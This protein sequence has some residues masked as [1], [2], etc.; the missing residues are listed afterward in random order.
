MTG[1]VPVGLVPLRVS[2]SEQSEMCSQLLFGERVE[3]LEVREKWLYLRNL[4]DDYR[5]WADRKMIYILSEEEERNLGNLVFK[6]IQVP[7]SNYRDN[8]LSTNVLLPGGS[9]IPHDGDKQYQ[10]ANKNITVRTA[11]LVEEAATGQRIVDLAR[12]YQGAPYLWGGK[13]VLGIDCSGLV[14]VVY[15]M[16]DILLPRDASQQVLCGEK[17]ESLAEIKAGDLAF[18]K[19]AKDR[20]IHVGIMIDGKHIIHASGWVKI[21]F[22][23]ERGI[24]SM[25]TGEY[26]HTLHSVRRIIL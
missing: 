10:F 17:V 22:M 15:S 4:S 18:F 12:Q 19:N 8:I 26:T 11:D 24:V 5:G 3:V 16:C 2:D 25:Q 23:D 9:R 14:Q 7:V 13:S 21:D 1:I 6:Y 20:V